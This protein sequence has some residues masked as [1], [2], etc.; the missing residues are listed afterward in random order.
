MGPV[1]DFLAQQSAAF[2]ELS[3]AGAVDE[4]TLKELKAKSGCNV[5]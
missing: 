1:G 2:V 5:P 4:S 3:G